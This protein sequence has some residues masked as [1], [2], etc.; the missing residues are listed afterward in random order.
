MKNY[1]ACKDLKI[2]FIRSRYSVNWS[3]YAGKKRRIQ[4]K[5]NSLHAGIF[6]MILLSLLTFYEI[7]LRLSYSPVLGPNSLQRLLADAKCRPLLARKVKELI[8]RGIILIIFQ[9]PR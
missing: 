6:L 4:V 2:P 1:P 8:E 5:F 9:A 7:N 3:L